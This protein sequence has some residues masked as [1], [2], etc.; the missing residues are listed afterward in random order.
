MTELTQ[1]IID[2]L[3]PGKLI[4]IHVGFSR[5]A[6][7]VET[8]AG[9]RCGIAA[10]FTDWNSSHRQRPLVQ[11]AGNLLDYSALDLAKLALSDSPTEISIGWAAIN[12]LIPNQEDAQADINTEQYLRKNTKEKKVVI[13]GHFPFV[14]TLRN[15]IKDLTVLELKP[16]DGDLPAEFAEK[17]LPD[18][19]I[20][21]ITA[22]TLANHTFTSLIGLT[23]PKALVMLVGPSTPMSPVLFEYGVDIL[24]GTYVSNPVKAMEWISQGCSFHQLKASGTVKLVSM[25]HIKR[26]LE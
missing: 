16:K 17:V 26:H 9:I 24:S 14:D 21:V 15:E 8:S 4:S 3:L 22:T 7:L 6:V 23:S 13:V 1:K 2:T 10:T 19:D 20:A 12:A 18:A 5:T 25:K 11:D